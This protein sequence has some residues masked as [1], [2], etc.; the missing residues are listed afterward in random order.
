MDFSAN[1]KRSKIKGANGKTVEVAFQRNILGFLLA[2]SQ[3]LKSPIDIEEALRY[4]LSP[5]PLS[6]AHGDGQKRKTNKSALLNCAIEP[7][8][9]PYSEPLTGEKCTS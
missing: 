8:V 6:I 3:E 2:K 7:S 5:I 1:D 9:S 4:P